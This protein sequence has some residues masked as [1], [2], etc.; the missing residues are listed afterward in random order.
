MFP[1]QHVGMEVML[2]FV[3]HNQKFTFPDTFIFFLIIVSINYT[4]N[5][6]FYLN[7]N[8]LFIQNIANHLLLYIQIQILSINF[9]DL[10]M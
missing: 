8:T 9:W 6:M 5:N 3:M 1:E 7:Q 2:I 4:E 10:Y